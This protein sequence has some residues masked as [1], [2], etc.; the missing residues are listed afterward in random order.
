MRIL[1]LLLI[2]IVPAYSA[3]LPGG[4]SPVEI[5]SQSAQFNQN[6]NSATFIGD[7][8]FKRDRLTV[9]SDRLVIYRN[10]KG[11]LI[12]AV[13]TGSVRI[14]NSDKKNR[15]NATSDMA[16]YNRKEQTLVLTGKLVTFGNG[17]DKGECE[18]LIYHI[19]TGNS[20]IFSGNSPVKLTVT[21]K[22]SK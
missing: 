14:K 20:E 1:L 9:K 2:F 7:V 17:I 6:K 3:A 16:V 15:F 5:D 4:S 22:E 19:D 13:A 21:P 11:E 18:K 8:V 12:K 10:K